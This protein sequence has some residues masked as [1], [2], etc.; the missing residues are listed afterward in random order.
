[1]SFS[2]ENNNPG[3]TVLAD[4]LALCLADGKFKRVIIAME[5]TSVY[6]TH[7][8]CFLSVNASLLPFM[9][10]V[11]CLNPKTTA[12]YKKSFIDIGK[13]DPVDA[14]AIADFARVGRIDSK[15]W[16]GSQF[17]ALQRLTRH[18]LHLAESIAREKTYMLN[19]IFLKFSEFALN[20]E[21]HP[22]SNTFG[23]TAEAVL[24]EF[25]STDDIISLP[26]EDLVSFIN[27]KGHN[28]FVDPQRTAE[29]LRQA[30]KNSYRLDK[31]L[32][33][34]LT[35]S[36]ASSFNCISA[37]EKEIK[38]IDKAIINAIKGFNPN[39]YQCLTSIPG[40]GF[41]YAAGIIAEMGTIVNFDSEASIAKYAGLYWNRPKSGDFEADVTRM[42]KAGNSY[43]RYY[44][45]QAAN[46]VKNHIPEY[47]AFY[48]KKFSEATTHHHT[49]AIA[50]S[51]RKLIRL[52]FGLLGK[53]Q[54]YSPNVVR[55][56]I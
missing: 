56:T 3:A 29:L 35:I 20:K 55:G 48:N 37:F 42:S 24:K 52:I 15:P 22:F 14:F 18:R 25:L 4:K 39:E 7:I 19:N 8:A 16:R 12:N 13:N 11:Y 32:Y 50:L 53:N 26:V 28:R 10:E 36:I 27:D 41:V 34:P 2:V 47:A 46:S 38:I 40:I 6:S 23:A 43:L 49:R 33:E 5:S 45:I 9:P 1:L 31:C 30:A 44:L 51:A 54:L 21:N 17:L